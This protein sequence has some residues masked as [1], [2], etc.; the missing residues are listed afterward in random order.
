MKD[1]RV[2]TVGHF[3]ILVDGDGLRI[4]N[5]NTGSYNRRKF[6]REYAAVAYAEQ[7][8]YWHKHNKS[9]GGVKRTAAHNKKVLKKFH[10]TKTQPKD[11]NRSSKN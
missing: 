11:W 3:W 5:T 7:L 9:E 6:T 1:R 8:M 4:V 2:A 10:Q